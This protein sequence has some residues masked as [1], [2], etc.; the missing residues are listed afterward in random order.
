MSMTQTLD[1]LIAEGYTEEEAQGIL[2]QAQDAAE[3]PEPE[4]Q[5]ADP[6]AGSIPSPTPFDTAAGTQP[7]TPSNDEADAQL[8]VDPATDTPD[9]TPADTPASV[10]PAEA[11][12]PSKSQAKRHAA[13]K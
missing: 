5:V 2:A 4:E 1:S 9:V 6:E 10:D 11:P 7:A 12:V 8:V 3:W 13:Q